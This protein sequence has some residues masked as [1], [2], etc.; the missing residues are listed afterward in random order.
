MKN[1][2]IIQG[3]PQSLAVPT[4]LVRQWLDEW[5]KVVFSDNQHR[6]KPEPHFY[7]FSMRATL[8]RRL[9]GIY[10]R[11]ATAPRA[12]DLGIERRHDPDRSKEIARYI[13]GGS[14][15][16]GLKDKDVPLE[17]FS[18]LRMPGWLPTAI[19]ANIL[20]AGTS[21]YGQ[22]ISNHDVIRVEHSKNNDVTLALPPGVL[23]V[24]WRP[25]VHPLEII[26]GQHRLW[27]FEGNE[28]FRGT[29]ELPVVAFYGLDITWQA[30]LFWTIN[31]KPKRINASL[32]F[33]LY[34]LLRSQDWIEKFEGPQIYRETRAQELTEALWN[35]PQSPW[36]KRIN[37]LGE[38]GTGDVTQAA[39]I[40]S[41]LASFVRKW[42]GPGVRS[43]GLFGEEM[44]TTRA[45]LPWSRAQQAAFLIAAWNELRKAIRNSEQSWAQAL[46]G[47]R[48]V[49]DDTDPAFS[50]PHSLIATDQGVRGFLQ[51]VNDVCF[52]RSGGLRLANWRVG[53]EEEA[54]DEEAVTQALI[55][56]QGM[57]S[58]SGFLERVGATLTKFDWRTSAAPGLTEAQRRIQMTYRGSGGYRELRRQ[59]LFVLSNSPDPEVNGAASRVYT[60]LGFLKVSPLTG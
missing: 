48:G 25:L 7:L 36:Y 18:G 15:W 47:R 53:L 58:I 52:E 8:L 13:R 21:R 20:P 43:G 49:R 29:Y 56:L 60:R 54:T 9:A 32:A 19:V 35:H 12:R 55:S 31:I 10:R 51:V 59:L 34:P 17:R 2:A 40:R 38:P 14:P 46:R 11:T 5:D 6:A 4:I 41:L 23:S 37:M 3:S 26:D 42:E 39:F 50:G 16:S 24:D 28:N 57:V 44:P 1:R 33:D 45:V 22:T 27:A 30:Y